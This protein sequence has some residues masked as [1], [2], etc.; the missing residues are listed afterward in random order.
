MDT[1]FSVSLEGKVAIVTGARGG[2]GKSIAL[3]L[4]KSGADVVITDVP[5]KENQLYEVAELVRAQGVRCLALTADIKDKNDIDQ[6]IGALLS[7]FGAVDLLVNV[8]GMYLHHSILDF[9]EESW[10]L[11]ADVNLKGVFLT[12][13]AVAKIMV[14]QKSGHIIN[15]SSDSAVDVAQGDGPYAVSK[16]GVVTF[17]QHLA[18]ELGQYGIRANAIAPGWIKT[19]MTESVW[20]DPIKLKEAESEIPLGYMAEPEDIGHVALFLA[21]NASRYI[22]GQ[23]IVANG[24][25]V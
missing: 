18:K 10:D 8:A 3:L 14:Q 25:R 13:Q 23:L 24:G 20:A 16:T 19:E 5:S 15:I 22:T 1:N 9:R 7:E 4:A 21:S 17:T 11:L 2:L 6:L 12:C